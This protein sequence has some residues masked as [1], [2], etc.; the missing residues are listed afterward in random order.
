MSGMSFPPSMSFEYFYHFITLPSD[1]AA[2][3]SREQ[4]YV[5][6]SIRELIDSSKQSVEDMRWVLPSFLHSP[7]IQMNL[8]LQQQRYLQALS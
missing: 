8:K 5:D 2:E 3:G 6:R 4:A 1:C 7:I